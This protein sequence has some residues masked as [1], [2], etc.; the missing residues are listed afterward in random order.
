M[1]LQVRVTLLPLLA[2]TWGDSAS[3]SLGDL[4]GISPDGSSGSE[5]SIRESLC[6]GCQTV[7]AN[8]N[9]LWRRTYL[10]KATN[11]ISYILFD[12]LHILKYLWLLV[13]LKYYIQTR[14]DKGDR[15]GIPHTYPIP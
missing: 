5:K 10:N 2:M 1:A 3:I 15:E 13:R 11:Q 12:Y 6:Y 9:G 8:V 4:T 7:W 14:E